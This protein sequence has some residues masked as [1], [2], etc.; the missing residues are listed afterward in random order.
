MHAPASQDPSAETSLR[1]VVLGDSLAAG[2][3]D[4]SGKGIT[5]HLPRLLTADGERDVEARS[6]GVRGATTADLL[7]RLQ[8]PRFR[9][10]VT[11]ADVVIAHR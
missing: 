8:Q 3:G 5:G 2:T 11:A 10:T 7:A 6:L 9:E 1:I 4:E